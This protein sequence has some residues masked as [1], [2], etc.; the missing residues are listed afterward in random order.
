MLSKPDFVSYVLGKPASAP[1]EASP[2]ALP[3]GL[4]GFGDAT[5]PT[6][7]TPEPKEFARDLLKA[8]FDDGQAMPVHELLLADKPED[9]A[10]YAPG[11]HYWA[12]TPGRPFHVVLLRLAAGGQRLVTA[13]PRRTIR[14]L[15]LIEDELDRHIQ[16]GLSWFARRGAQPGSRFE[17]GNQTDTL[18]VVSVTDDRRTAEPRQLLGFGTK[19]A[20]FDSLETF[21]LREDARDWVPHLA[22]EHFAAV[23]DRHITHLVG[24]Q[25]WQKAF[26]TGE[27]R[28]KANDLLE[29]C[30]VPFPTTDAIS[31]AVQALIREV[32][33]G[34]GPRARALVFEK[35]RSDHYIAT[36]P[37]APSAQEADNPLEGL[38]VRDALQRVMGYVV[39]CVDDAKKAKEV[40]QTLKDFNVFD[41][42]VLVYPDGG[43]TT[44]ELWQ[45]R[46]KIEGRLRRANAQVRGAGKVVGILEN[47]FKV[48]Q[49]TVRDPKDLAE[50]L[51][52]RARY[53]RTLAIRQL[54]EEDEN[55]HLRT[56][57]A[58]F[59]KS[60]IADLDHEHFAD[61]FA[62]TV[63]NG[64][65]TARWAT[66]HDTS[67]TGPFTV[68]AALG[69][70]PVTN[71]F[72]RGIFKEL[73]KVRRESAG[74]LYMW[75]LEDIASLL[76]RVDVRDVFDENPEDT[77]AGKD[78]VIH[79]FEDF[80]AAYDPTQRMKL[81]VYYTP[82]PSRFVHYPISTHAATTRLRTYRRPR[83]H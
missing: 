60:L 44:I 3:G 75:M 78:P 56:L 16:D 74:G 6:Q 69:A 80:L 72:L 30:A 57:F 29:A 31:T 33:R 77:A 26:T 55:G 8:C 51:A 54:G 12:K 63:T 45:G 73:D 47:F 52:K 82:P 18:L 68:S 42:V 79:F 81:G 19:I 15:A 62:Q 1:A 41:N 66:R 39:Y 32:G 76:E 20:K 58:S 71:P 50:S 23:Y 22:E 27:H 67:R 46:D 37:D 11:G 38:V 7:A 28:N 36:N 9:L 35:L 64:L 61:Y 49:A 40:S 21:F 5:A 24:I 14:D 59:K 25:H 43:E 2:S 13:S 83:G 34:F 10:K 4:V 53:L 48:S 65:L 70:I 17:Q